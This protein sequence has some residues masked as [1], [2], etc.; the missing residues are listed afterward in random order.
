MNEEQKIFDGKLFCPASPELSA[1]KL[2][3]HNLCSEYNKTFQDETEKRNQLVHEIFAEFGEGSFVQGPMQI[4]YG[5]HTKIGHHVFLN[6]N[7][8]I[9]DDAPVTIGNHCD[10]GP[11]LTIVTPVHP[12]V[13][14]ERRALYDP[15]G[16]AKRLCWAK[17]VVIGDNCWFGANVTVCPGVTIG[18]GCVIGAGSVV[19]RDIP[20]NSFAAGVPA[21]VIRP[22]TEADSLKNNPGLLGDYLCEPPCEK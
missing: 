11:G 20:A 9:Q 13:A 5:R 19:T 15:D 17:P 2:R 8:M 18:E 14:K 1:Y 12:L 6:F 3:C 4:H 16:T 21:R 10:F 22:I 7:L